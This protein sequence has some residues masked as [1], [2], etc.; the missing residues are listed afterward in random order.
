[1]DLVTLGRGDVCWADLGEPRGS[2]AGYRRPVV[3]ISGDDFNRSRVRTVILAIVTSSPRVAAAPGNVP[4]PAGTAG[5]DRPCAIN[6]SQ[7]LTVDK[8]PFER[9]VGSLGEPHLRQLDVGL[10]LVL[11]LPSR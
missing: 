3:V 11:H 7:L 4:L 8:D 2:A 9:P 10:H 1:M 6:V 5:L